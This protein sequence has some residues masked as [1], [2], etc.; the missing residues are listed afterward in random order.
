VKL[1]SVP[2][3]TSL[4]KCQSPTTS[5]TVP[6]DKKKHR[7]SAATRI[8][9][10][11]KPLIGTIT[12]KDL[13]RADVQ[14]MADQITQGHTRGVH[15]GKPRGKA[16]VKGGGASAARAVSLLGGIYTWAEKRDL[17]PGPNPARNVDTIRFQPR[18][19][20]L[21]TSQL[22]ELGKSMAKA[23]VGAPTVAAAQALRLIAL[24]GVRS[25]EA[26]ASLKF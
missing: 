9:R 6:N 5:N 12:A 10:H 22:T 23:K 18:D 16:V 11:L 2:A 3:I 20:Y 7:S 13:R 21:S 8:S 19:R 4:T 1:K 24:T 17:V 26:A 15:K 25:A 14:K